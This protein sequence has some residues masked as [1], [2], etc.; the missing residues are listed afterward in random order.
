MYTGVR[1][2]CILRCIYNNGGHDGVAQHIN[3][4]AAIA[5]TDPASLDADVLGLLATEEFGYFYNKDTQVF[6]EYRDRLWTRLGACITGLAQ[7]T[8]AWFGMTSRLID[9]NPD[10]DFDARE[11]TL[12]QKKPH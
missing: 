2:G 10:W 5:R 12:N 3:M 11:E 9:I 6:E 8:P 4:A 7:T 1:L